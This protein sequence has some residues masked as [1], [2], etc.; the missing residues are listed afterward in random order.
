[1]AAVKT[2]NPYDKGTNHY[3]LFNALKSGKQTPSS[4]LVDAVG[5]T[6]SNRTIGVF[7]RDMEK[8]GFR[9]DRKRVPE[10]GITYIL[11]DKG[12][13][14]KGMSKVSVAP[15]SYKERAEKRAKKSAG[16]PAKK[17]ASKP[18]E[19]P[20]AKAAPK[21]AVKKA[22]GKTV[23]PKPQ[24][25]DDVEETTVANATKSAPKA[26]KKVGLKLKPKK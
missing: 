2:P 7:L 8:K 22:T 14:A 10:E 11:V 3:K 21:K 12:E 16:K 4:A 13:G 20:S 15:G 19:K 6:L 18:A 5:G 25:G 17:A 26:A 23:R 9:F 24:R 1:M